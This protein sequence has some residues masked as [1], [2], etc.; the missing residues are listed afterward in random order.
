MLPFYRFYC[1]K[2]TK[3]FT[4]SSLELIIYFKTIFLIM[5]LTS[6][7][8]RGHIGLSLPVDLSVAL[9][10]VQER[11][12]IGSWKLLYWMYMKNKMTRISFFVGRTCHCRIMLHFWRFFDIYI[13]NLWD[14]V[15]KISGKPLELGS[16]YLARRLCTMLTFGKI[17]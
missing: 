10:Y 3:V 9:A 15:N 14:L 16:W 5:P 8:L 2:C 12:E 7:K 6:K 13:V 1:M 17:L 11:F 4:Q